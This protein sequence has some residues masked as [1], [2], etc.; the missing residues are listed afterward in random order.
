M[1]ADGV[2]DGARSVQR[3]LLAFDERREQVVDGVWLL[4]GDGVFKAF[5]D[6]IESAPDGRV[7]HAIGLGQ[8]LERTGA[9]DELNDQVEVFLWEPGQ[10]MATDIEFAG[11]AGAGICGWRFKDI[12]SH[13]K[14]YTGILKNIKVNFCKIDRWRS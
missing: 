11:G 12:E 8:G 9:Q 14:Q 4:A 3:Q 13:L 5:D 7:G 6:A 10:R 1:F 2:A